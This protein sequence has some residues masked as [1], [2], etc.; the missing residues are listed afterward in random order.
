MGELLGGRPTTTT[1]TTNHNHHH[2]NQPA[3]AHQQPQAPTTTTTTTN[4]QLAIVRAVEAQLLGL[5]PPFPHRNLQRTACR[6]P[7]PT[8]SCNSLFAANR[9]LQQELEQLQKEHR[10]LLQHHEFLL[11]R[12]GAAGAGAAR[13][14]DL[15]Q[16]CRHDWEA[17]ETLGL[18]GDEAARFIAVRRADG[19]NSCTCRRCTAIRRDGRCTAHRLKMQ[20]QPEAAGAAAGAPRLRKEGRKS[21]K[22]LREEGLLILHNGT[23]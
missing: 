4:Q 14:P 21:T 10:L 11:E 18:H 3:T 13:P 7:M 1:T 22:R 15:P 16:R 8:C 20:E 6:L 5:D 12:L 23:L 2:H 19:I 9:V 17:K